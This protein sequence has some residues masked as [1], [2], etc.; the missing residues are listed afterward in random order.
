MQRERSLLHI[1]GASCSFML[2]VLRLQR[3]PAAAPLHR[4]STQLFFE[5]K[6]VVVQ[7]QS[8]NVWEG[9][10]DVKVF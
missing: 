4:T 9:I 3:H 2:A 5:V 10:Y 6:S 1:L 7:E 8:V